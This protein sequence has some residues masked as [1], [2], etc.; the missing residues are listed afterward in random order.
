MQL[1][2][3][4][5][6]VDLPQAV[7]QMKWI[8]MLSQANDNSMLLESCLLV[9]SRR[10]SFRN[11]FKELC[12]LAAKIFR[13]A[14]CYV[15]A[16]EQEKGWPSSAN[17]MFAQALC[18]AEQHFGED[19][20]FLEP[21]ACPLKPSWFDE[22]QDE[23][24]VA[25]RNG[26][27]FMGARVP[28]TPDHMTGNAVYGR[29]W[30]S[31]APTLVSVPDHDAFDTYSSP[32]VLPHCHVTHLIQHV[33]RRHEK[34]WRPP[35]LAIVDRRA[36]IFHQDKHGALIPMLDKALFNGAG[37]D[38]P[39][40]GYRNSYEPEKCMRKFYHTQ[41]GTKVWKSHGYS[42]VFD[43]VDPIGGTL[44]GVYT[45]EFEAEQAALDDLAS[46]PTNGIREISAQEWE[47]YTKKKW[48]K[49]ISNT[50][51]PLSGTSPLVPILPTPSQSPAVLVAEPINPPTD[52]TAGGTKPMIRDINDVL[53]TGTV[54]P[55]VPSQAP[56]LNV[57]KSGR[58]RKAA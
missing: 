21:D 43:R 25:K 24:V 12:W 3:A 51:K 1:V 11:G 46:N 19:I 34:G 45:T 22:V 15:P 57:P 4:V 41:N 52:P 42:F 14:R 26:K 49:P 17:W 50:S 20:L 16:G 13:E 33:F 27:S 7:R 6:H 53:K 8:G 54:E 5:S 23:W 32:Q 40:F 9:V 48:E 56:T 35:H 44:P 47:R 2:I 36:V 28:H 10:A 18:H 39:L 30:R 31:L 38:H 29:D 37:M 58:P 55:A